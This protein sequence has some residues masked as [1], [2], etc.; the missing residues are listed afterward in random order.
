MKKISGLSLSIGA[1][2]L[3]AACGTTLQLNT[4][5]LENVIATGIQDQ[6]PGIVVTDVTCPD[7]PIQLG[8]VFTCQ[9][10]TEDGQNVVVTVTQTDD[11][12]NVDWEITGA[13]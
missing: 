8:D 11:Q 7:R 3:F 9:A 2:L 10:S 13:Q 4:D 6:N 5:N 12:G 1:A